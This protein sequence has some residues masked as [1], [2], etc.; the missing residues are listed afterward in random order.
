MIAITQQLFELLKLLT[1][2]GKAQGEPLEY[3][4]VAKIDFK[5]LVPT[6][7]VEERG[8]LAL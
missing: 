4:F 3:R 7:Y 2:L 6:Q 1:S 5:G 8:Q